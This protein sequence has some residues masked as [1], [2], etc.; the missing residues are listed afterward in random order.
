[1]GGPLTHTSDGNT[2]SHD[3]LVL[4]L[5]RVWNLRF[6]LFFFGRIILDELQWMYDIPAVLFHRGKVFSHV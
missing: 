3:I 2:S 4:V 6:L 1:M 5:R